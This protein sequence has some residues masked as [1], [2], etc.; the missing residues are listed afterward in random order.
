MLAGNCNY[1]ELLIKAF[2]SCMPTVEEWRKQLNEDIIPK[3]EALFAAYPLAQKAIDD[4]KKVNEYNSAI[5]VLQSV[6]EVSSEEQT[7]AALAVSKFVANPVTQFELNQAK[8]LYTSSENSPSVVEKF[9][10]YKN[11]VDVEQYKTD[12]VKAVELKIQDD[13][14][15]HKAGDVIDIRPDGF[16]W[17]SAECP[18]TFIRIKVVEANEKDYRYLREPVFGDSDPNTSMPVVL[19][20]HRWNIDISKLNDGDELKLDDFL[21][22]ISE[23]TLKV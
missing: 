23:K 17:G 4:V 3:A 6:K 2:D 14:G 16:H 10:Y 18:P 8:I 5:A 1:M 13:A 11:Q 15:C 21:K 9:Q 20:R 22:L 19:I 12:E 7:K